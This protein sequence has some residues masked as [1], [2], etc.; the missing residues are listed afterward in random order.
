M[1]NFY[2][3]PCITLPIIRDE[4]ICSIFLELNAIGLLARAVMLEELP[5]L[6]TSAATTRTQKAFQAECVELFGE[7]LQLFGVPKSVGQIYGLLYA[8]PVP[9][10]FSDIVEQ[11]NISKG[12]VSQGLQLLRS[13]GAIRLLEQADVRNS[14]HLLVSLPVIATRRDY[15]EPELSL[16]KLMS[17]VLRER[18]MPLATTGSGHLARLRELAERD[19][20]RGRF[21]L[22]R[23]KQLETWRRRLKA[24]LPVLTAL[25]GPKSRQ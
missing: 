20:S 6:I 2:N 18:L 22:D 23:V 8:S 13:L 15:F 3:P 4:A 16:R 24:V 11:L 21:Y 5:S 7:V 19:G 14:A 17:G 10:C 12:S 25:L 1:A 9:L